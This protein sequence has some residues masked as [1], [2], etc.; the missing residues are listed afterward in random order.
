MFN[1]F[2]EC[3]TELLSIVNNARAIQQSV[4][5]YGLTYIYRNMTDYFELYTG[6]RK[7]VE[8]T[9]RLEFLA[10]GEQL[11]EKQPSWK[12]K[13]AEEYDIL[14]YILFVIYGIELKNIFSYYLFYLF[15]FS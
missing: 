9:G 5:D 6:V 7:E 13:F 15:Y 3:I 4:T 8:G 1:N 11:D 14:K 12:M 10:L 2:D